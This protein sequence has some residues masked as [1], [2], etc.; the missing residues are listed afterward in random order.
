MEPAEEMGKRRQGQR[1]SGG[2]DKRAVLENAL[3]LVAQTSLV[4]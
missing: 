2:E 1:V 3:S 4:T